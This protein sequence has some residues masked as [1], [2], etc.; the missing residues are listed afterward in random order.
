MCYLHYQT[1][2]KVNVSVTGLPT[3]F[4]FCSLFKKA[5][6][7]HSCN[8]FQLIIQSKTTA[9]SIFALQLS[10]LKIVPKLCLGFWNQLP[11]SAKKHTLLC[12][13]DWWYRSAFI[14]QWLLNKIGVF[15]FFNFTTDVQ[16]ALAWRCVW[17]N[18][19]LCLTHCWGGFVTNW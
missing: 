13:K 19:A 18:L 9:Y 7:C 5:G 8:C 12:E 17:Q 16:S 2:L 3:G 14:L 6:S 15:I 1:K 10:H 4:R 11:N